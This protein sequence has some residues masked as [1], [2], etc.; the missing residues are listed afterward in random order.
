MQFG[1][2]WQRR[3]LMN[4][5]VVVM[6]MI[7]VGSISCCLVAFIKNINPCEKKLTL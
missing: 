5:A 7:H 2:Q 1:R 3:A 6:Q 4:G